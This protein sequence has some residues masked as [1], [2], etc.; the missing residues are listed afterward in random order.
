MGYPIRQCQDNWLIGCKPLT[1]GDVG[2]WLGI[3][4]SVRRADKAK[5]N[6]TQCKAD[7]TIEFVESVKFCY[8]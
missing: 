1:N 8:L 6:P 5:T 7:V 2:A 4:A 3:L